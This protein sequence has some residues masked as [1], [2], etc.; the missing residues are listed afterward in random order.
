MKAGSAIGHVLRVDLTTM[1]F[2]NRAHNGQSHAKPLL[3][4][5]KELLEQL[6]VHF[7]TN[8]RAMIAH[9]QA[10]FALAIA[11]RADLYLAL[12][13]WYLPH[14]IKG[15]THQVNQDLLDLDR[16][17]LNQRQVLG[18]RRFQ[19]AGTSRCIWPD[20]MRY[21]RDQLI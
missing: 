2:Y 17:Y 21:I 19:L 18:Q 14:G 8:A 4:G 13:Q 20:D 10:H 5:G 9:S 11:I 12:V 1:S 6:F 16:I 15:I 7:R 3:L